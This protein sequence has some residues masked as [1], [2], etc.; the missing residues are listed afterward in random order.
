[1]TI[2]A[3]IDEAGFGPVLGP[4]VVSATVFDVPQELLDASMW[5]TLAGTVCRKP[6][7]KRRS[8]IPIAD[9][10][11]LYSG[12]RGG[13]G[14]DNLERGVLAALA[15]CQGMSSAPATSVALSPAAPSPGEAPSLADTAPKPQAGIRTLGDLLAAVSPACES[16]AR[17]CPWYAG[18]DLPLPHCVDP[19]SSALD[20]RSLRARLDGAGMK[21]LGMHSEI[22]F[23]SEYNRLVTAVDNKS[24][25]LFDVAG[26]L[27]WRVWRSVPAGE[28][29]RI[30]VDHQGG[31]VHYLQ[32]LQLV[33]DGC[34]FRVNS[35]SETLS[36]YTIFDDQ[37]TLTIQFQVQAEDSHLSVALAS[38]L[39]KFVR[40]LLMVVYNRY[41]VT[42]MPN[43]SPTA[44]YYSDGRRFFEEIQP[45]L[46][47]LGLDG[48]LLWRCR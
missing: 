8:L 20:A 12:L 5:Q 45:L 15:C 13:S 18:L 10:K 44:G 41:W 34:Q 4:L 30:F 28:H 2:V 9:S 23:E 7:T 3:G 32:G 46:K 22:L 37:R 38:M 48:S 31:R 6:S 25:L 11:K 26:R 40:E 21:L 16:H 43:L 33:F 47:H 19:V 14:L 35:E 24:L 42:H 1:M 36:S 17:Q 39:S 29:A 27:L